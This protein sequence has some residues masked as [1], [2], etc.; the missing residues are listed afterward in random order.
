MGKWEL[1]GARLHLPGFVE[2][3]EGLGRNKGS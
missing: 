2:Q 1:S 3:H